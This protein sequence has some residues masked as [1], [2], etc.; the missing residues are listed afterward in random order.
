MTFRKEQKSCYFCGESH[1]SCFRK[2][3]FCSFLMHLAR[4]KVK[5]TFFS[6]KKMTFR[7][8]QKS[9]SFCGE[10]H[11]SCFR[12]ELFCCSF[13]M[14]LAKS[15]NNVL[16]LEWKISLTFRK[17]QK[18]CSFCGE[19]H[20][21]CFRKELFCSFLMHLARQKVKITFFSRKK[22]TFRKEQKSCSFGGESHS[23]CVQKGTQ[24]SSCSRKKLFCCSFLMH[25]ARQKVQITFFF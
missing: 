3:L 10:S 7:K 9:C 19:S 24:H 14:H 21:S 15:T 23:H 1:S 17:E 12:K 8:E 20:S 16:F 13:L 11:S 4:Q 5:I 22:M 6:R 2:E 25:L 18:S